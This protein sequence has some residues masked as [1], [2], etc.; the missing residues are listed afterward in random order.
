MNPSR[1]A[2]DTPTV[3]TFVGTTNLLPRTYLAAERPYPHRALKN[4]RDEPGDLFGV[5][6]VS[7]SKT[8]GLRDELVQRSRVRH[9][10][11]RTQRERPVSYTHLRAHE[12][13]LDLVCR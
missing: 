13:V 1:I 5:G 11:R 9:D 3:Q 8:A 7:N 2:L 10:T 4:L 12:T 6:G